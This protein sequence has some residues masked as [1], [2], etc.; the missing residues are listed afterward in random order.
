MHMD[1]KYFRGLNGLRFIAALVVLLSHGYD[2]ALWLG[3]CRPVTS[4]LVFSRGSAAVDFFFTLSGF[5]I[6]YLLIREC[7]KTRTVNLPRFYLRRISRIWPLYYLILAVGFL[8]FAVVYPH[9]YHHSYFDFDVKRG[10]FFYLLFLPNFMSSFYRVG[11]LTPLWSIG[12]E[13]QFYLL[14][15]PLVK[16]CRHYLVPVFMAVAM[17]A[18]GFH[19]LVES[20]WLTSNINMVHF[21][22]TLRFHYMAVGSLFACLLYYRGDWYLRSW[23]ARREFQAFAA[24]VIVYH[25]VIGLP[26]RPSPVVWEIPLAFAYGILIL[27]VSVA[28][29]SLFNLEWQPLTYLGKI[30]YG[31]YMFHMTVDYALRAVFLRLGWTG[32]STL[33]LFAYGTLLLGITVAVAHA[34]YKYM[35]TRF[36]SLARDRVRVA[37]L[38]ILSQGVA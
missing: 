19:A 25:Y 13:E 15:A 14:W 20:G 18:A 5:L 2:S 1:I 34:S 36:L 7:I 31:I 11:L 26:E 3:I 22:R 24:L 6:S 29:T 10:L 4:T 8:L 16:A 32:S 33:L 12:V 21:L 30:S 17:C 28:G 37:P 35:E 23:L 27:S 9:M 38:G